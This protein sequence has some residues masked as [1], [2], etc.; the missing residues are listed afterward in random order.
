MIAGHS[1]HSLDL[2]D[3][4][5]E[6]WR[7]RAPFEGDAGDPGARSLPLRLNRRGVRLHSAHA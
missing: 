5:A 1:F 4:A 2:L 6:S 7:N 3:G